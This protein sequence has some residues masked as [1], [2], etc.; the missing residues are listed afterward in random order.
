VRLATSCTSR[1]NEGVARS[2]G[3]SSDRWRDTGGQSGGWASGG[4]VAAVWTQRWGILDLVVCGG[5]KRHT[6][7]DY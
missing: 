1:C 7:T 4:T 6:L 3:Q 5:Q 2:R